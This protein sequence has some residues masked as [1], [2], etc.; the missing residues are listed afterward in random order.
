MNYILKRV[1]HSVLFG[2]SLFHINIFE[3]LWSCI[4]RIYNGFSGINFSLLS[5]LEKEG[6]DA[7][8]YIDDWFEK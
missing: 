3:G 7:K 6:I 4:K 5:E 8:I 2:D 1:N